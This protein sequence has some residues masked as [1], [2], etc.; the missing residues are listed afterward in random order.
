[1]QVTP[2]LSA[3]TRCAALAIC[4]VLLFALRAAAVPPPPVNDVRAEATAIPD[5]GPFPYSTQL[6]DITGA[7]S[8]GDPL[9]PPPSTSFDTN[10]SHSVWYKFRPSAAG[11][12]TISTGFD[13]D[14]TFR[15][16][17]MVM[18]TAA[19]ETAPLSLFAFNEDSGSLRAAISTNL[20]GGT[21][22]Y[23]V[24]W[25][26]RVEVITNQALDLQLRITKPIIP[27]NDTCENPIVIPSSIQAP[28]LT[29]KI[30]T[31]RATT[32]TTVS[33]PCV[34][35]AGAVAS[36]DVWYRFTPS[37]SGTY[38]FSTGTDTGTLIDDTAIG[39]YTL[40]GGCQFANQIACN[41][42]SFGRAVLSAT[43]AA[44]TTYYIAV[45]DNAPAYVPSETDLQLRVSPATAPTVVTL[46][47]TN[48]SASGVT[49][50]GSM[51]ANGLLSRF[52]FEW[53][54]T[55]SLGSTSAVRIVFASANTF[56]TNAVITGYQPNTLYYY[57]LVATNNLGASRGDLQ[58][59]VWN[60]TAPDIIAPEKLSPTTFRFEFAGQTNHLYMVQGSTNLV[61]WTDLGLARERSPA[62]FEFQHSV[63]PPAPPN[64][65]YRV[66]L[67]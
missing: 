45:W 6:T 56:Y 19:N 55:P 67:P 65:F 37:T 7:T 66:R 4:V 30:D 48:L 9:L 10:I 11:L 53:G 57:R 39:L 17:T 27:S 24:V 29:A 13:T 25:V 62:A 22:Y 50:T 3:R 26:G 23:V 28:Y 59:F 51:N 44:G 47:A 58:T 1:M 64:R 14:T 49:L 38:I 35:N 5:A 31:T 54:L 60:N 63:P 15:D 12:Y 34:T 33:P 16:S 2:A 20:T 32:T 52:W 21:L 8:T 43:L 41:D 42:N 36:R 40:A 18:Y 61:E 46:S